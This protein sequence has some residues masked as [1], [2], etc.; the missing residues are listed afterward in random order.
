MLETLP[1][2]APNP[3]LLLVRHTA[4]CTTLK[5]KCYGR[6]DVALSDEG[7]RH[8]RELALKL[9]DMRPGRIMHSGLMR[10]RILAEG[11]GRHAGTNVEIDARIQEFHFGD[12]ELKTWAEIFARVGHRM[13]DLIHKPDSYRP[14]GGETVGEMATRVL[15]WYGDQAGDP[16]CGGDGERG[17]D[18]TNSARPTIAVMHGGPISVIR[19]VLAGAPPKD[20]PGFVP[21]YGA[22]VRGDGVVMG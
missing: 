19:G 18:A 12:W 7:A 14:P 5:G 22:I 9:A 2:I 15:R 1:A 13:S 16:D 6:S 10:A 21:D 8:A 20:W 11:V 3:R 17:G 4:V